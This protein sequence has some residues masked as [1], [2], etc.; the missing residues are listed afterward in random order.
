MDPTTVELT[1]QEILRRL[2]E[3]AQRRRGLSAEQLIRGYRKGTLEDPCSLVDLLA[4]ADLLEDDDPLFAA[5]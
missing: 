4:L 2:D 5:A 3:G 1:R